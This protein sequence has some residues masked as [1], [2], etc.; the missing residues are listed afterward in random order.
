[1]DAHQKIIHETLLQM[2]E[3][4]KATGCKASLFVDDQGLSSE[5]G[6]VQNITGEGL[7]KILHLDNGKAIPL[8]KIMA[9]NGLF[10]TGFSTC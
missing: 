4:I 9:V 5:E 2:L 1:M 7:D 10:L 6:T 8:R 3:E